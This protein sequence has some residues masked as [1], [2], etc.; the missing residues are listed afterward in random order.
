MREDFLHYIW[1]FGLFDKTELQT[2]CGKK[3]LIVKT[4]LANTNSGPDFFNAKVYI[5][6]ALWAGNIEIHVNESDWS[7]HEHQKDDAY[8]N[9]ILHVVYVS[10]STTVNARGKKIPVVALSDRISLKQFDLYQRFLESKQF[11]PCA[12][13]IRGVNDG[14]VNSWLERILIERL[15]RKSAAI[16][17]RL[18]R[19]RGDW[20]QTF[21]EQ[22]AMSFGFKTNALPFEMLAMSLPF[23]LLEKYKHSLLTIEAL[24]FGQSGMLNESLS[25]P[26]YQQ[27]QNEYSFLQ[28]KHNLIPM[29]S[30]G[31]KFGRMRPG[32]FPTIR[33]AQLAQLIHQRGNLFN[34]IIET[35]TFLA[36]KEM[37][38]IEASMYWNDHYGFGQASTRKYSKFIGEDSV[39]II[40]INVVVPFLFAY[41][42][43][44]GLEHLT[45]RSMN[46]LESM[47][48]ESN[49]VVKGF[50]KIGLMSSD[51]GRSQSFLEL[52]SQYCDQKKCLN[53]SIGVQ[54]IKDF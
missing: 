27:L 6:D 39:D 21:W 43:H 1:K 37:F 34:R 20:F 17:E 18:N 48:S 16:T 41:S 19:N 15:E 4:G 26:Y 31:W 50:E 54:L 49:A 40:V 28:K 9:V 42:R 3:I 7:R 47:N 13:N 22:M 51:A 25:E 38:K 29:Q 12:Q 32:N 11:I 23:M 10:D 33:L 24:L 5:D 45:E 2:T 14:I 36:I 44:M 52:K 46:L 35:D 30:A 53:C 8:N